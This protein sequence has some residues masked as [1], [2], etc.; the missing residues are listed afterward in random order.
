MGMGEVVALGGDPT[1]LVSGTNSDSLFSTIC[2][3]GEAQTLG[4]ILC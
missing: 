2:V 4:T 1:C 3:W